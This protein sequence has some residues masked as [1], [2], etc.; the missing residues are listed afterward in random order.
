M[1]ENCVLIPLNKTGKKHAGKFTAIVSPEDADLA[2]LNWNIRIG[3]LTNQ[4]ARQR[5]NNVDV[6]LHRVIMERILGRPLTPDDKVDHIDACGLNCCRE[7]LRLA[8]TTQNNR[9]QGLRKDNTSGLKGVRWHKHVKKWVAQISVNKKTIYLGY[10]HNPEEAYKA[11]C[12][13]AKKY[14][15]EF[16]NFGDVA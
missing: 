10:Y 11:Y 16:A 14:H 1:D 13:A 7:N 3:G 4:Y 12:E 9:N 15:G 8:T 6:S 2:D 5:R